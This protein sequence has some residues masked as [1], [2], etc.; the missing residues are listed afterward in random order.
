MPGQTRPW[1]NFQ[2]YGISLAAPPKCGNTTA[3]LAAQEFKRAPRTALPAFDEQYWVCRHPVQRFQSLFKN[4]I[5][6]NGNVR[7]THAQIFKNDV[8]SPEDLLKYVIQDCYAPA[9]GRLDNHW[10]PQSWI[11]EEAGGERAILVPLERLSELLQYDAQ[12]VTNSQDV[13]LSDALIAD[14]LA[15]YEDDLVMYEESLTTGALPRII[16]PTLRN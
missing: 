13:E 15:F 3:K 10:K 9:E 2:H 11:R 8:S 7:R 5:L 4:K 16:S 6:R 12:N 14:I 1:F